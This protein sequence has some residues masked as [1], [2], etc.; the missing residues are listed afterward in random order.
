MAAA[1]VDAPQLCAQVLAES[2]FGGKDER[3]RDISK[4]V[5]RR[6][7][8]DSVTARPGMGNS[9]SMAGRAVSPSS[10]STG[11]GKL[12][13]ARPWFKRSALR[14]PFDHKSHRPQD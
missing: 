4:E 10:G 7:G 8:R 6:V 1:V 3:G 13:L 11:R 9:A 14:F 5:R 2:A 12:P